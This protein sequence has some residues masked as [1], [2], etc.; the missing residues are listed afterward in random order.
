MVGIVELGDSDEL[1]LLGATFPLER[2]AHLELGKSEDVLDDSGLV[3]G[4][5][6]LGIELAL[7]AEG[8]GA[9]GKAV[10]RLGVEGR[11]LDETVDEDA[12]MVL[13]L[14][15]LDLASLVLL[16]DGLN[17]VGGDLVGD[18]SH[19][20]SSLVGVDRVDEGDL[21]GASVGG[22]DAD[23]PAVSNLGEG[24]GGS[25]PVVEVNVV[26]EGLNG[27]LLSV[28]GDLKG[29][30]LG[31]GHGTGNVVGTPREEADHV[32]VELRHLE[33]GEVRREGD[34]GV[35]RLG[36][37]LSDGGLALGS[38]VVGELLDVQE[39]VGGIDAL[40]GEGGGEDVGELRKGR[41]VSMD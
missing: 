11:V 16:L 32:G 30:A 31:G 26:L 41:G 21:L 24:S 1:N 17:E 3:D 5:E 15:G 36:L 33:A 6:E 37:G 4:L 19:V 25:D 38:H 28:E 14:L 40:N 34:L 8:L 2:L 9:S 27:K 23:L 20:L 22:G 35:V 12:E 13:D 18:V 29:L 39:A 7:G 10:L